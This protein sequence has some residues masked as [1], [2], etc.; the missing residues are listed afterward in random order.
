[1]R[2]AATL[3]AAACFGAGAASLHIS[4]K[5]GIPLLVLGGLVTCWL[6]WTPWKESR[7]RG[8]VRRLIS[9]TFDRLTQLEHIHPLPPVQVIYGH[10]DHECEW[11][12]AAL[13]DVEARVLRDVSGQRPVLSLRDTGPS[14]PQP[15]PG[16]TAIRGF[17]ANLTDLSKRLPSLDLERG[18]KPRD[19]KDRY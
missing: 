10:L 17:R 8:A 7:V 16:L 9:A 3:L 14:I 13:G 19:W 1:V 2:P 15:N 5:V 4:R 6:V 12:R 11:V 18:F